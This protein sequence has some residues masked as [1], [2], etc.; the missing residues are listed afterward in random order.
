MVKTKCTAA[1][2][3]TYKADSDQYKI[4]QPQYEALQTEF[5]ELQTKYN[6]LDTEYSTLQPKYTTVK[7]EYD[8]LYAKMSN[9][10]ADVEVPGYSCM[11]YD[12]PLD[13][14]PNKK[15]TNNYGLNS[16]WIVFTIISMIFLV[17]FIGIM[18]SMVTGGI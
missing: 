12:D 3:E 9:L 10:D 2:C 18:R 11:D 13:D 1:D 7:A 6:T 4:L 5:N 8:E 14:I 16:S 17:L 15:T